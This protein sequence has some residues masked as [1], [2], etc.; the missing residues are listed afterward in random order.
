MDDV[1]DPGLSPLSR[2]VKCK[3]QLLHIDIFRD[4]EGGWLLTVTNEQRVTS[5]WTRSFKTDR[6]ALRE[7]LKAIRDESP[8][9]FSME[10]P[11]KDVLH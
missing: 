7:A 6:A 1:E 8:E 5:H 2:T 11:Y 4:H 9:G 3:G 10:T